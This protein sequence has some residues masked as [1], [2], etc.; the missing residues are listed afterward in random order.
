VR[1]CIFTI[2]AVLGAFLLWSPRYACA[3]GDSAT[4]TCE[5][6]ACVTK[7]VA[8]T[9]STAADSLRRA[10]LFCN[11]AGN[12]AASVSGAVVADCLGDFIFVR[13]PNFAAQTYKLA[14]VQW[15]NQT[16]QLD[17]TSDVTMADI[18]GLTGFDLE[19]GKRYQVDGLLLV[20]ANS[21]TPDVKIQV[22]LSAASGATIQLTLSMTATNGSM[23]VQ[24]ITA[25]STPAV[26]PSTTSWTAAI[27]VTGYVVA[28]GSDGTFKLQGAQNTSSAATVSFLVGSFIE[29]KLVA[30]S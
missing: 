16:S 9:A 27:Q 2:A 17:K 14:P 20:S 11:T 19:N 26:L 6:G 30:S 22:V 4:D 21:A 8:G 10:E 7:A 25:D 24:R 12:G 1:R 3:L 5:G 28:G 15:K 18:P 13:P 23:D 29:V